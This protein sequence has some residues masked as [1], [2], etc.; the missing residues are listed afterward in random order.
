[1]A[2]CGPRSSAASRTSSRA[3]HSARCC[4]CRAA[5]TARSTASR[6]CA[7]TTQG[8]QRH[9][10]LPG[11]DLR[12]GARRDDVQ[13]RG[14]GARRSPTTRCTG[15]AP[16]SGRATRARAFRMGRAIKAGRV[17]TTT[18]TTST[19]RTPPSAA[20]RPPGSGARTTSMMLDHYT[21]DEVPAR[22]LRPEPAG[23]LLERCMRIRHP[24]SSPPRPRW[25]RS[26]A[27]RAAHG[28]LDALPV[29]GLLRRQLPDLR[30]G[31]AS[32]RSRPHD[33]LLGAHRR[34]RRSTSTPISASAGAAPTSSSTSH[35]GPRRA[36]RSASRTSISSRGARDDHPIPA[37]LQVRQRS[38]R[39]G[40]V[41]AADGRQGRRRRGPSHPRREAECAAAGRPVPVQLAR[42]H[43]QA[44]PRHAPLPQEGAAAR[45]HEVRPPDDRDGTEARQ[46]DRADADRGRAGESGSASGRS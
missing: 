31:R 8:P 12:P 43:G 3:P 2:R 32:S 37:R 25:R 10:G 22:L 5:W 21:A 39:R 30:R 11:G 44:H 14:R 42:A 18:A 9:A 35:P 38:H 13:G 6:A 4:W 33:L 36:S 1:M 27:C 15:S 45:R 28:P 41:Q 23:V 7:A 17:W 16:A 19:R 29:G 46:E 26:R 40:G 20:T 24:G 34:L